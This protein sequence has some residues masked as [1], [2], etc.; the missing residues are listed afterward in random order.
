VCA[1]VPL[2]AAVNCLR[3]TL[4]SLIDVDYGCYSLTFAAYIDFRSALLHGW[5]VIYL[6]PRA[7]THYDLDYI[8]FLN[9][10]YFKVLVFEIVV[11][12]INF[13]I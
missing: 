9:P 4:H 1:Q 10:E 5:C 12:I 2:L 6:I 13:Y 3:S 11:Y 8:R 7:A